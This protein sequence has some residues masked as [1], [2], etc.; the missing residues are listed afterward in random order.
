MTRFVKVVWVLLSFV[1]LIPEAGADPSPWQVIR[2]D[3]SQVKA[4]LEEPR[5]PSSP[6]ILEVDIL[7]YVG[8]PFQARGRVVKYWS[9]G[10]MESYHSTSKC[11]ALF[12]RDSDQKAF[13]VVV[14]KPNRS[15][16]DP[17]G[18][19]QDD[20][21]AYLY[22]AHLTVAC[23]ALMGAATSQASTL[24]SG[25]IGSLGNPDTGQLGVLQLASISVL[26]EQTSAVEAYAI[27]STCT[28]DG[29]SAEG[30]VVKYRADIPVLVD[31]AYGYRTD[32]DS[33]CEALLAVTTPANESKRV[34]ANDSF[35][36]QHLLVYE[37]RF[38]HPTDVHRAVHAHVRMCSSFLGAVI[39]GKPARI[40]GS[41]YGGTI[42]VRKV[43]QLTLAGDTEEPVYTSAF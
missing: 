31:N 5:L 28:P 8:M 1:L 26:T 36:V 42:K 35:D 9:S 15:S 2:G 21:H 29:C 7:P 41:G 32:Y 11:G 3:L 14:E 22:F 27:A 19:R 37:D 20:P 6:P 24:I 39:S 30:P 10:T 34:V 13:D 38:G 40:A 23:E 33:M 4:F 12:I 18:L 43:E 16:Q 25:R 17:A